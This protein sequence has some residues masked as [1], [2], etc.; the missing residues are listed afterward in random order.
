MTRKTEKKPRTLKEFRAALDASNRSKLDF[1]IRLNELS[2]KL[3]EANAAI[4]YEIGQRDV[5]SSELADL[6]RVQE[7]QGMAT[8]L[9]ASRFELL[10]K[11]FLNRIALLEAQLYHFQRGPIKAS[12]KSLLFNILRQIRRFLPLPEATKLAIARRLTGLAQRLQP[13][14]AVG[15]APNIQDIFNDAAVDFEFPIVENPTISIIVPVY[16][17]FAQTLVCLKSIFMQKVSVDYEVILADDC[18]P[19]ETTQLL[20]KVKGLRY[21]RNAEN[22]HFLR[23]CNVNAKHARGDYLVFLNNDTIVEPGWLQALYNTFAE[24][25]NVGIVGSK[26]VYPSGELQEAGGIIWDDASGWNWGKGRDKS[27]P[28]FNYLRDADYVSGASFMIPTK[29]WKDVGGFNE[30]LEKAYYEDTDLCFRLRSLG[31]RVLYQPASEV[32]HIEGLSSGTDLEAGA[33]QYQLVNQ[34]IFHDEWKDD[35]SSHGPN[36]VDPLL[37]CDRFVKGHVLYI[38]AVTPEPKMD[39]GSSD[40]VYAMRILTEA[41]YRV[42][43]VPGSNFAYWGQATRDLQ[44]IGVECIYHPYYSNIDMLIEERG[45]MFDYVVISRAESAGLFLSKLKKKL[46][47][48]KFIYNTVDLHFL[49]MEREAKLLGDPKVKKAA[50][51]MKRKEISYMRD[52]DAV[53]VL[54][55]VEYGLLRKHSAVSKKLWTIPLIR[56][57]TQRLVEFDKTGDIVFIGGYRHPPN[58]DAV[59]WL[60]E[61]IWPNIHKALPGVK[62]KIC[63]SSMPEHFKQY[64]SESVVLEGFVDDLDALLSETRLTVAPLRYG[65]GLKGKIATSIGVG[66]PCVGTSIAFEGMSI[67]GLEGVMLKADTVDEFVN[68]VTR[69]YNDEKVWTNVSIAGVNYHNDNYAYQQVAKTYKSLLESIR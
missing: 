41:N 51:V 55:D 1:E 54:S 39:S 15:E 17:E 50:A 33:K 45:D 62:L 42:H 25:G 60:V 29:I 57:A 4:A 46:P 49:R 14:V 28:L 48:A 10:E 11:Q 13:M 18:S 7:L 52:S 22:L 67:N 56:A 2:E 63:G 38:D 68:M 9:D 44:A 43:F 47:S 36:G 35:L 58:V 6:K 23:N 21:F 24:H 65:A 40:A 34:K 27:H 30:A 8:K 66:V 12:L 37:K 64:A 53:I 19:D 61:D 20:K 26:L 3:A 59:E 69:I 31:Y 32:I 16:N 5:V